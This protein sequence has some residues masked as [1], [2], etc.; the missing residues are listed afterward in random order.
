MIALFVSRFGAAT[1]N[2]AKVC[3]TYYVQVTGY[4]PVLIFGLSLYYEQELPIPLGLR[5][6]G[7]YA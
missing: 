4:I 6:R 5:G 3:S 2:Q 7:P 1:V